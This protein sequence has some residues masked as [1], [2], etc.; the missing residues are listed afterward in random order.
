M[1]PLIITAIVILLILLLLALSFVSASPSVIK[2]ISGPFGQRVVHGRTGWRIPVFERVDT[3]T[4]AMISVDAQTTN[5][6]PTNDYINV[7]VDAA[8]KVRIGVEDKAMFMAATRNFLYKKPEQISAEVRDTLEGHL[9]AII[10]QMKLTQ[11]VTDRATF[12]EKVQENAKA[13][14]AEMGLQIVAFNIQG[15]TDETGVIDNLGVDN[16]E[17]IRK[18]AAI[19][20]AQAQRDVAIQQ[21]QAQQEANDA[22]VASELAISQKKTDLA[23]KQAE[24]KAQQDTEQ[25][26]ADAAYKIQEQAQRKTI[27][28][29]TAQADIANQ[30]QQAQIKQREVEVT[31]QTLQSEVNAR[32]DA[33]KY[34][35]VQKADA[36]LYARQKNAE[37][38]AYE[39]TQRAQADRDAMLAEA[40]GVKAQ[41]EAEAVATAAKLTAEAQGLERKAE[42]MQKMDK[43]AVLQMW[44][45]V[46]PEVAKAV[47]EPLSKVDSITMYGEGNSAKMVKDITESLAQVNS[48]LADSVG[49][50]L[51]SMVGSFVNAKVAAPVVADAVKDV[52]PSA[53]PTPEPTNPASK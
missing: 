49:L 3:M 44:F 2:V 39:R 7:K 10:G 53:G 37:A 14:L 36:D 42:A 4:A 32:A 29:A 46:L 5:F 43:A 27:V 51:K 40:Q 6:V 18:A 16:T 48:G 21:A 31:K 24:L 8:V 22:Q 41:G 33:Q 52:M 45:D 9:R 38:E 20:K 35:A 26:K 1:T 30:E 47:A 17:Q 23:M 28:E 11:I 34:A 15:V 19:A 25:A 12:A 13:D 50:D